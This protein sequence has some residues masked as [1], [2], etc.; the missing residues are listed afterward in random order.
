VLRVLTSSCLFSSKMRCL[1]LPD[2][3]ATLD[4]TVNAGTAGVCYPAAHGQ[5]K[6]LRAD[7]S[8]RHQRSDFHPSAGE[9]V[10]S[11]ANQLRSR[12]VQSATASS[13]SAKRKEG[14]LLDRDMGSSSVPLTA[15]VSAACPT[16]VGENH[17][18]RDAVDVRTGGRMQTRRSPVDRRLWMLLIGAGFAFLFPVSRA[19][20]QAA[21]DTR[22]P[23]AAGASNPCTGEAFV[24]SGFIHVK[25]FE[26]FDPNYHVSMEENVESFQATTPSGVRYVVQAIRQGEDGSLVTGDDFYI[27]FSSHYT[28]NG[29]GDLTASFSDFTTEC[30]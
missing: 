10:K 29:N 17:D 13:R 26:S 30:R 5:I 11:D 7:L 2:A 4:F 1:A 12:L 8:E 23:I 14:H 9:Y 22:V 15:N 28:Y 16:C 6:A 20:A 19:A 18:R 25:I 27:R 21:V 3:G 24:G